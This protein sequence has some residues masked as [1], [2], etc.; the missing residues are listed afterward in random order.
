MFILLHQFLCVCLS[1]PEWSSLVTELGRNKRWEASRGWIMVRQI[2]VG[3]QPDSVCLRQLI[4]TLGLFYS[5]YS[6]S[7]CGEYIVRRP[8][9]FPLLCTIHIPGHSRL[10][11]FFDCSDPDLHG[12]FMTIRPLYFHT[13]YMG[14]S[15]Q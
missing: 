10:F 11:C 15:L 7:G 5:I 4:R 8:N 9:F 14:F 1:T 6:Y 13:K 2:L 3:L 12:C